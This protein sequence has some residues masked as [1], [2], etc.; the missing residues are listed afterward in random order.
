MA[1]RLA[2]LIDA[3]NVTPKHVPTLLGEV[4]KLG[5]PCLRRIYG[6]WTKPNM[7]SWRE[8]LLEHSFQ[9]IQQFA[10]TTGKNATDGAMIIDA[11]DLLHTGRFDGF[12]LVSSDSDFTRLAVRIREQGLKVFGFGQRRT[13]QPF[14]VSC[15][16]FVFLDAVE[17]PVIA[18]PVVEAKVATPVPK[19]TPGKKVHALIRTAVES[20]LAPT[21]WADLS[22]VGSEIRKKSPE[23][24]TKEYGF[25]QLALLIEA[26]GKFEVNRLGPKPYKILVRCKSG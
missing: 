24:T 6:D 10:Y 18:A 9:P 2:L 16:R 3:D 13:P 12:C 7:N 23:F 25:S 21:G 11:M 20:S 15:D 17:A 19:K 5:S 22:T 14:V 26:T 1:V 4:A 8:C